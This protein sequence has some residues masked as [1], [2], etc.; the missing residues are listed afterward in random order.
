MSLI[1]GRTL[2]EVRRPLE[3]DTDVVIVGSGASGAVVAAEL[4]L[5]WQR[6]V[7]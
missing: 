2:G 3:L 7:I 6:V 5:S 4:E 1:E